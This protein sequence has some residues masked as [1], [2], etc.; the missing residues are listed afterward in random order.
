MIKEHIKSINPDVIGLCDLDAGHKFTFLEKAMKEMGF[1]CFS[2]FNSQAELG[3]AIFYKSSRFI[4][5]REK[6]GFCIYEENPEGKDADKEI[7]DKAPQSMYDFVKPQVIR[8]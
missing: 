3:V 2:K 7:K 6:S 1:D 5:D 8:P 4:L